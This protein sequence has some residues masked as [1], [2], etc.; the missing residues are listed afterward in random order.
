MTRAALVVAILCLPAASGGCETTVT[1]SDGRPMPPEPRPAPATPDDARVNAIALR[2]G[3]KPTDTDGNGFPDQIAVE[4]YLFA[5]PHPTPIFEDGTFVFTL[6]P[7]GSSI[8]GDVAPLAR[9]RIGG[10]DLDRLKTR[11]P[12]F[13]PAYGIRL[14]LL[15]TGGDQYPLLGAN[16]TARFEPADGREPIR[17]GDVYTIQIGRRDT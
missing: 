15:E 2:I 9:W 3:A 10:A 5:Q 4:A 8:H 14:S 7:A 17:T 16:L 6:F 1:T 12:L 13:G 11:S